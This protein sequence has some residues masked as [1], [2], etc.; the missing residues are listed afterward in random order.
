MRQARP[1]KY[2]YVIGR[3]YSGST[4]LSILIGQSRTVASEG[5]IVMSFREGFEGRRCANGDV[6]SESAFW[7][8]VAA[9]FKRRTGADFAPAMRAVNRQAHYARTI[10]NLLADADGAAVVETKRLIEA[11]YDSIAE[12]SNRPVVLDS[13]KERATAVFLLRHVGAARLIH[14]VRGPFGMSDSYVRRIKQAQ[15]FH[16]F[17]RHYRVKRHYLLATITAAL[18]WSLEN[19]F[20]EMLRLFYPARIIRLHYEDLC[21]DPIALLERLEDF[22]GL[23]LAASKTA[24][25]SRL[26]MDP[27][28][29]LSGNRMMRR[30]EIVFEPEL[31][32]RGT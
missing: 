29:A 13:S 27:G 1:T 4:I 2:L 25:T 12:V 17:R 32:R 21:N 15:W 28:H 8:Q 11:L 3:G 16:M 19:V 20:C 6:F 22:T 10:P 18:V 26:P 30:K 7:N 5:E 24:A 23:S 31:A 14:L 9:A